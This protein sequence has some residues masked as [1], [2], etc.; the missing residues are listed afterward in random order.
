MTTFA[1]HLLGT[2][3]PLAVLAVLSA[4]IAY[5]VSR[6]R[7]AGNRS[8]ARLAVVRALL[9]VYGVGVIW[10][11]IVLPNPDKDGWRHANLVPLR[12]IARSLTNH[13]PGYGILNFWGNIAAF[14]PIG[15][16]GYLAIRDGRRWA[17][18]LALT[19]GVAFSASIEVTQYTIGRS[20]DVDDV[21]LNGL[22]VIVGMAI[23]G[24]ARRAGRRPPRPKVPQRPTGRH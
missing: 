7:G 1:R 15:V 9:A 24:L 6:R 14:V 8:D 4:A 21:I 13:E 16:L 10:W 19:G 22:G 17:W 18:L 20:A 2:A 11:T 12:E 3:A 23:A 5:A